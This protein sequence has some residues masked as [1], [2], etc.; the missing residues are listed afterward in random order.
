MS[1]PLLSAYQQLVR[2][3]QREG[4]LPADQD[5]DLTPDTLHYV[6]S[7]LDVDLERVYTE[8]TTREA[9]SIEVFADVVYVPKDFSHTLG[10][11]LRLLSIV[12]RQIVVERDERA[13]LVLSHDA[14]R[15]RQ[16]TFRVLAGEVVG[17]LV[18]R[19]QGVA[20]PLDLHLEVGRQT[21]L[22][23]LS[24]SSDGAEFRRG[25]GTLPDEMLG[26]QKR[27]YGVLGASFDLA[28]NA[29]RESATSSEH[30]PLAASLLSWL[31]RW[32]AYPSSGPGHLFHDAV[33]LRKSL[34][35]TDGRSGTLLRPI[36]RRPAAELLELAR[37]DMEVADKYEREASFLSVEQQTKEVA[38][39]LVGSWRDRD[40]VNLAAIDEEIAAMLELVEASR[41][42]VRRGAA[43]MEKRQ[44]ELSLKTIDYRTSAAE[45]RFLNIVKGAFE[46][47]FGVVQLAVGIAGVCLN[48]GVA[49]ALA[50]ANPL[51]FLNPVLGAGPAMSP[52][53][54]LKVV[55]NMYLLPVSLVIELASMT[56]KSKKAFDKSLSSIA[57]VLPKLLS[58]ADELLHA[59]APVEL[60][61]AIGAL[62][63][64]TTSV[65]DVLESKA[66]WDEFEVETNGKLDL[67]LND[68]KASD[69][70]K[71]A[72]REI[73]ATLQ[74]FAIHA[75]LGAEQQALLAQRLRELGTLLIRKSAE[76]K[77]R[78][79][80]DELTPQLRD[81]PTVLL[82]SL[83]QARLSE[84]RR[85]FCAQLNHYRAA[86]FY[87]HLQ[88]PATMPAL[89]VPQNATEMK[90]QLSA[91]ARAQD[92][93]T[94]GDFS[95]VKR[96]TR[97]AHP[98]LFA[99]LGSGEQATF[100]IG[101]DDELFAGHGLVRIHRAR[102]KLEGQEDSLIEAELTSGAGFDDRYGKARFAFQGERVSLASERR[103][104]VLEYDDLLDGV[105]PTP[106]TDW[107]L[108]VRGTKL[109]L[110]AISAIEIE[111]LGKSV[112]TKT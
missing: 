109:S 27:L 47:L 12:A 13:I 87:Q 24:L 3:L 16:A 86:Y 28:A 90:E 59:D 93:R 75:R 7:G 57:A 56:P 37:G 77:R 74:K 51:A 21:D 72:T 53:V 108:S 19:A 83:Q 46:A 54:V 22:K 32:T 5:A 62:V 11:Q 36:P 103:N 20:E 88:W 78:Q 112:K 94:A 4:R 71:E 110:D 42:A 23:F 67:V 14:S 43:D 79:V 34:P 105:C 104:G 29:V 92:P 9:R 40:S 96:L 73:K 63:S 99:A 41:D 52:K 69:K 68:A 111:L 101:L 84:L 1:N 65:S 31:T 102:V 39:K 76:Q 30:G 48:P 15:A 85:S 6:A 91:I 64:E 106:F 100:E 2:K 49:G 26:E 55:G 18:V 95:K 8:A 107:T 66:I 82:R 70:L 33:A 50:G 38:L 97:E 58:A 61:G 17:E 60:A 81:E 45:D 10:G 44:F 35:R 25:Q 98:E 89:S 80:L